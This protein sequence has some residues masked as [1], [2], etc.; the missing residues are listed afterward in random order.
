MLKL[1][2]SDIDGTLLPFD[3][4]ALSGELFEL[5]RAFHRRGVAFCPSSGRQYSS[6]HRLFEPVEDLVYFMCENGGGLYHQGRT[7]STRP[8]P[9]ALAEEIITQLYARPDCEVLISAGGTLYILPVQR[10]IQNNTVYLSV[11]SMVHLAQSPREIP[12]EILRVSAYCHEGSAKV[13]AEMGEE[14][15]RRGARVA[16]STQ[17]WIDFTASTK[18][19][20]LLD[21]CGVLGIDPKET[22]ALGDNFN[23][24]PL[25]EAAGRAY[26]MESAPQAMLDR[27]PLHCRR[28]E[29]TL[30]L[31][32]EECGG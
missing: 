19:T 17:N 15:R 16:V 31:L 30:R 14:W 25:L 27:F 20:G 28:A 22:A 2:L 9:R 32:L 5:I 21:L 6:L 3:R 8:L 7:L 18:G 11:S 4:Q 10:H 26:V 24:L 29:D 13:E 1:I 23:D 12:G